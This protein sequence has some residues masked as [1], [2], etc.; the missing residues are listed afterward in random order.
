[1]K[2]IIR[3]GIARGIFRYNNVEP[4]IEIVATQEGEPN[5]L[6][7][8]FEKGYTLLYLSEPMKEET[9]LDPGKYQL[10]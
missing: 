4:N 8:A 6:L 5:D 9:P 3:K 7:T 10:S 1:M 2:A